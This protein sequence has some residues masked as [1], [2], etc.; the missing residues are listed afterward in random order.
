MRLI[1]LPVWV[2]ELTPSG[3]RVAVN[4]RTGEAVVAGYE[5]ARPAEGSLDLSSSDQRGTKTIVAVAIAV[6][7]VG[8]IVGALLS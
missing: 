1:M 4:G 3:T 5:G 8:A 6:L 2:G 7:V